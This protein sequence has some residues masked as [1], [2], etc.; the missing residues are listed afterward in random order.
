V[1]KAKWTRTLLLQRLRAMNKSESND[2]G[3]ATAML[4]SYVN[5]AE[6]SYEYRCVQTR[7]F[8]R[9]AHLALRSKI[10]S[11]DIPGGKP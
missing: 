5:D 8:S 2:L 10:R 7:W 11:K 4:L 6:I 3:Q 1:S 9:F